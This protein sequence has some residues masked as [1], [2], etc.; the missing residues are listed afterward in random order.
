MI[1]T[2][3]KLAITIPLYLLAVF[4]GFLI[5]REIISH[6]GI[7]FYLKQQKKDSNFIVDTKPAIMNILAVVKS[8]KKY[9]DILYDR[10]QKH[11]T[12][13]ALKSDM[14]IEKDYRSMNI[15]IH[16]ISNICLSELYEK[17][18]EFTKKTSF[19]K[20]EFL[21]FLFK[22]GPNAFHQRTVFKEIFN[23]ERLKKSMPVFRNI[24]RSHV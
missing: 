22:N 23:F 12:P 20:F 10:K 3:I 1:Y 24:V 4:I 18:L 6:L 11:N 14:I 16:P 8:M 2:V 21:G 15:K 9:K 17:E 7:L 19:A 13:E 5:I